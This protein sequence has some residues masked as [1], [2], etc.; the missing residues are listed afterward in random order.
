[1][2]RK[3]HTEIEDQALAAFHEALDAS[4]LG[5]RLG[6]DAR[7]AKKVWRRVRRQLVRENL[8][9]RAAKEMAAE[10]DEF[11]A[12]LERA[13]TAAV[14]AYDGGADKLSGLASLVRQ[15]KD[16]RMARVQLLQDLKLL[17][18]VRSARHDGRPTVVAKPA[19][20]PTDAEPE[21]DSEADVMSVEDL[22][23]EIAALQ[24]ERQRLVA[25]RPR[26]RVAK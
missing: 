7:A 24:E 13:A 19:E 15:L 26:L 18:S 4:Q 6:L 12:A 5:V 17:P 1:M 21:S 3:R 23:A 9:E 20:K 8:S 16:L 14:V 10:T 25:E 2:P 11:F 22:D